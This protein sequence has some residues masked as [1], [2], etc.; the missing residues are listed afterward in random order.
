[1]LALWKIECFKI[2]RRT[3]SWVSL[4]IAGL[5]FTFCLW[6]LLLAMITAA[7]HIRQGEWT[8]YEARLELIGFFEFFYYGQPITPGILGSPDDIFRIIADFMVALFAA[9]VPDQGARRDVMRQWVS[10]GLRRTSY[11]LAQVLA[12]G[13]WL[14]LAWC[15]ISAVVLLIATHVTQNLLVDSI[16][17]TAYA[18][19]IACL[20]VGN[21]LRYFS[22]GCFVY[23]VVVLAQKRWVGVLAGTFYA[24]MLG[25]VVLSWLD[26]FN[27]SALFSYTPFRAQ[28]IVIFYSQMGRGELPGALLLLFVWGLVYLILA[29]LIFNRQDLTG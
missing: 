3:L 27:L 29:A 16:W 24:V 11:V 14:A 25:G 12:M 18:S 13:T 7:N 19:D 28:E 21:M 15:V 6:L 26:R 1:M 20:I 8:F 17:Q 2:R 5:A 10:H 9:S 23:L 4:G 22:I